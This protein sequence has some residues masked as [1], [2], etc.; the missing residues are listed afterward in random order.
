MVKMV[1]FIL[2]IFYH[3]KVCAHT[4]THIKKVWLLSEFW[5]LRGWKSRDRGG[6]T[7]RW[8]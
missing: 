6:Q 4:H 5:T 1:N 8:A 3:N 2:Y 7:S